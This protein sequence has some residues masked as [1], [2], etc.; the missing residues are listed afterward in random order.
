[1]FGS[2]NKKIGYIWVLY[3]IDKYLRKW[4]YYVMEVEVLGI[5]VLLCIDNVVFLMFY[6]LYIKRNKEMYGFVIDGI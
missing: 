3:I 6:F 1:M 5:F 2:G 4:V